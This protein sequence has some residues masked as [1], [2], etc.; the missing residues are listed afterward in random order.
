MGRTAAAV[1]V[2]RISKA[3]SSG[4]AASSAVAASWR[5]SGRIHA[6]DPANNAPSVRLT[7]AEIAA[8]RE[9]LGPLPALAQS[10][11]DRLN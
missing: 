6:L 8:A 11:L 1:H 10:H 5:R 4:D 9:R 7:K 2:E 3:I